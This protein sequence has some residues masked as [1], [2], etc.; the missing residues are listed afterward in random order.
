MSIIAQIFAIM[1]NI[2]FATIESQLQKNAIIHFHSMNDNYGVR[3]C[4]IDNHWQ[5]NYV[6]M[7]II[8]PSLSLI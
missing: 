3:R 4:R 5:W 6:G 2:C 7:V 8:Y 1:V